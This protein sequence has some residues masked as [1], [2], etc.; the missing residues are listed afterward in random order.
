M[1]LHKSVFF[2]QPV[3]TSWCIHCYAPCSATTQ[4]SQF[5]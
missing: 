3:A 2:G 5:S 4:T 1:N